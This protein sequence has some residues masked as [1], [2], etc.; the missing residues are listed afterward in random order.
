MKGNRI[1][2]LI[3]EVKEEFAIDDIQDY[4]SNPKLFND[5][6]IAGL[7]TPHI[8]EKT[9]EELMEYCKENNIHNDMDL[10]EHLSVIT[11]IW[12]NIK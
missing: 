6:F 5:G 12:G 1:R 8:G 9:K 3:K 7:L 2:K 11:N 10:F 4:T